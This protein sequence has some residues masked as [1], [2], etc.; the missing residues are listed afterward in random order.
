M[1]QTLVRLISGG[2]QM[3]EGSWKEMEDLRKSAAHST[4]GEAALVPSPG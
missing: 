1:T 4:P 2:R 3:I